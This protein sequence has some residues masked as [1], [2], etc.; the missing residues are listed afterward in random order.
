M[1]YDN[2]KQAC[3]N[4]GLTVTALLKELGMG[5]ANGT[6]WKDGSSPKADVVI[7][8]SEFLDVSTDFLLLGKEKNIADEQEQEL[9]NIFRDIPDPAKRDV[10]TFAMGVRSGSKPE[11]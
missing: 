8:I 1:F 5:T 3:E 6:F 9:I 7:Q 2:L 11:K 4:K 10:I